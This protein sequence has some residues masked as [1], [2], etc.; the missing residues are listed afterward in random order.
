MPLA[1]VAVAVAVLLGGAADVQTRR[2][3]AAKKAPQPTVEPAALS[4]VAPLGTGVMSGREYCDV[5]AGRDPAEG[6]RVAI[7]PHAGVARLTFEL[8]NRHIYSEELIRAGRAYA[9]Y[10]ATI[11]VL[12]PNNDLLARAAVTGSFRSPA[13]LLDRIAVGG[14]SKAVK[15]VA[16]IGAETITVEVP[17]DVTEVSFLGERLTVQRM[18]GRDV[19]TTAGRPIA[20]IS[21]VTVEYTPAPP[22][23]APRKRAPVKKKRGPKTP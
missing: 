21:N 4:C 19:F 17:E 23:P 22:K 3:P 10:I 13:D 15:A 20:I 1:A 18:L 6:S 12:T 2:T 14:G 5:L 9:E 7:P 16:P 8:H 11:G